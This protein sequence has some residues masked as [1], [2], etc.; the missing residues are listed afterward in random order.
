[1]A[2]PY[3]I[4]FALMLKVTATVERSLVLELKVGVGGTQEKS[5]KIAVD[6]ATL[7]SELC[8][9]GPLP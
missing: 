1:M 3:S 9:L 4:A 6:D 7:L 2:N 5:I 8:R